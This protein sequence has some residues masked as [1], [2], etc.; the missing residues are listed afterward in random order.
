[1]DINRSA[2]SEIECNGNKFIPDYQLSLTVGRLAEYTLIINKHDIKDYYTLKWFYF[3]KKCL[4]DIE[5]YYAEK[6]TISQNVDYA[7]KMA[8]KWIKV[9][10]E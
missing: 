8:L 1:V 10:N 2:R 5:G 6:R 7:L 4:D 9:F 3:V